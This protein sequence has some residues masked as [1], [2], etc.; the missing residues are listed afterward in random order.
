MNDSI[1]K[2]IAYAKNANPN[3][4]KNSIFSALANKV[5]DAIDLKKVEVASNL[6]NSPPEEETEE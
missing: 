6:F 5:S 2:A 3:G 4:V 1:R